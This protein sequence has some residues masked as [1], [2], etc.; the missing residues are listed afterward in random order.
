MGAELARAGE[1]PAGASL[2]PG[3]AR[4]GCRAMFRVLTVSDGPSGFGSVSPHPCA[5]GEQ[6]EERLVPTCGF[7]HP[8]SVGAPSWA[9]RRWWAMRSWSKTGV[10]AGAAWDPTE[11]GV[12]PLCWDARTATWPRGRAGDSPRATAASLGRRRLGKCLGTRR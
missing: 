1:S 7:L 2:T 8:G 3:S 9:G 6:L 5:V 12:C 10:G 4:S 11:F